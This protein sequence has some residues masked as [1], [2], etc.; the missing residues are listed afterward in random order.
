MVENIYLQEG[1]TFS[2]EF[3]FE[4]LDYLNSK[5]SC[6]C[7]STKQIEV[8]NG[9]FKALVEYKADRKGKFNQ[10]IKFK[11]VNDK[12]EVYEI[13]LTLDIIVE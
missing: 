7:T 2:K 11:V 6:G 13:K 8:I 10:W 1:E 3:F 5:T 4:G 9:G 12:K